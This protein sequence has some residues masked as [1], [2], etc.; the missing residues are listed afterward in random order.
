MKK[1][2]EAISTLLNRVS[3]TSMPVSAEDQQLRDL[4]RGALLYCEKSGDE[5]AM[6]R[7]LPTSGTEKSAEDDSDSFSLDDLD[8]KYSLD[9]LLEKTESI[10]N[11][12]TPSDTAEQQIRNLFEQTILR[13]RVDS[14][15]ENY[16]YDM[17]YSITQK[18]LNAT[19]KEY[20]DI[21]GQTS[22]GEKLYYVERKGSDFFIDEA[23]AEESAFF[24]SLNLF[25]LPA[26]ATERTKDQVNRITQ[27]AQKS[28]VC[29]FHGVFGIPEDAD[30]SEIGNII[31]LI[32][33][34][35]TDS[36]Y[37]N[38]NMYFS[39]L[40]ILELKHNHSTHRIE[41]TKIEQAECA[42]WVFRFR[43]NLGLI[44][45][46]RNQLPAVVSRQVENMDPAS[47]F[48]IQQLFLDLNTAKLQEALPIPEV[49]QMASVFVNNNFTKVYFQRLR[50]TADKGSVVFAYAL[51]PNDGSSDKPYLFKPSD[52]RFYISPYYENGIA[53]P[54]KGAL[55]TLNYILA[56]DGRMLP[57]DLKSFT[58]N[59]IDEKD[60]A[61]V[62]GS[63][64][65]NKQR[66][67]DFAVMQFTDIIRTLK[68][69]PVV[70][71]SLKHNTFR[72]GFSHGSSNVDFN[73]NMFHHFAEASDADGLKIIKTKVNYN[74]DAFISSYQT[75]DNKAVIECRCDIS[76][77]LDFQVMGGSSKGTIFNKT[78][79]YTLTINID[80][81][82]QLIITPSVTQ[83]DNGTSFQYNNFSKF[84][85][86]GT[87][88]SAINSAKGALENMLSDANSFSQHV[89]SEKTNNQ[90]MWVLP[91][92][93]T[94]IFKQPHFSCGTDLTFDI[95]YAKAHD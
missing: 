6:M 90:A 42:P 37:V 14:R 11:G 30:L 93:R 66:I 8:I 44:N 18:A 60:A 4:L 74:C 26:N 1:S 65:I 55:Y 48:S 16:N 17:V 21:M 54:Q 82:G 63:M 72:L 91:G 3:N 68:L 88:T 76:S 58:W 94:F 56:C 87:A 10:L 59:W 70:E 79:W 84:I 34:Q 89:F 13:S 64:S 23:S 69:N 83:K 47:M 35:V 75:G 7:I 9:D 28:L 40:C 27:A 33:G 49:S 31:E 29:A 57:R 24:D 41:L 80:A 52:F 51:K 50:N 43:V 78:I 46:A 62:H 77:Y 36:T 85:S 45:V 39:K 15:L 81:Y 71:I 20:I 86:L 32:P 53:N 19:M 22:K 92:N 38:Y 61:A 5:G 67:Y 95:S 2:A 73:N 12:D 25:E